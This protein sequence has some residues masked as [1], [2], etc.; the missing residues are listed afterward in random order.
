M[1]GGLRVVSGNWNVLTLGRFMSFE[2]E[3]QPTVNGKIALDVKR[4]IKKKSIRYDAFSAGVGSL[5][6]KI[7]HA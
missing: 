4:N 2:V 7:K 5:F 3:S 6:G 1:N